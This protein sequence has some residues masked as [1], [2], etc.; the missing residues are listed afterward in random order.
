M[1]IGTPTIAIKCDIEDCPNGVVLRVSDI[2]ERRYTTWVDGPDGERVEKEMTS[3]TK[4]GGDVGLTGYL[5]DGYRDTSLFSARQIGRHIRNAGYQ[6]VDGFEFCSTECIARYYK[7]D[8]IAHRQPLGRAA[9]IEPFTQRFIQPIRKGDGRLNEYP[10]PDDLSLY[11]SRKGNPRP[12]LRTE[13]EIISNYR[14]W[15]CGE[16]QE[17]EK[18]KFHIHRVAYMG[19]Y[20]ISNCVL[21]CPKCSK[22]ARGWE[23]SRENLELFVR[24]R[25]WRADAMAGYLVQ[26]SDSVLTQQEEL[27][28]RVKIGVLMKRLIT[29]IYNEATKLPDNKLQDLVTNCTV[30]EPIINIDIRKKFSWVNYWMR[31]AVRAIAEFIL[32]GRGPN[33]P[34]P[35]KESKLPLT[36]DKEVEI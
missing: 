28:R 1:T 23:A 31:E 30:T 12:R 18:R 6:I 4:R 24:E 21:L 29:M 15:R 27:A 9:S 25:G 33:P 26:P 20:H 19:H 11:S 5:P 32:I 36:P 35:H 16:K 3:R 2:Q 34:W 7:G 17:E 14:C 10:Y 8:K 13:L 22:A